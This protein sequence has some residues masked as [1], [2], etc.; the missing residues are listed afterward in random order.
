MKETY[1]RTKSVWQRMDETERKAVMDYGEK[2]KA[3]LD[4]ARTERLAAKEII[5]Q[6]EAKGFKPVYDMKSLK[7]G[8][9]V[10][11][12]QKDKSVIL[13]V[14]GEEPVH[15][16][17]KIVGSHIDSPRLDLKANPVHEQEGVVYFRTHYYGGIKKYQWTC[18]P[19]ALIGVV[20]T[21][22]GRKVEINIGLK[23]SDPVFYISD[24]LIHMAQDQMKKSLAEGITGEQLQP[25]IATNSDENQKPKEALMKMFKDTYG[26]EEEDLAAA[27]LELVPAEK[28]RDVGF[29][30]SLIAS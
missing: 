3:F 26:I 6:A 12:N 28:S 17:I 2:Y 1:S 8:D 19:L 15:E 10:Y 27:E 5:R 30:R 18:I 9:K 14:I 29:D 7:A 23:D 16:G 20:Y 21:K 25:I 4:T 24:L 11:W 22:D 13:A